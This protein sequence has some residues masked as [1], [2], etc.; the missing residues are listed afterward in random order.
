M[1]ATQ[2]GI[3]TFVRDNPTPRPP[4]RDA[5]ANASCGRSSTGYS[6]TRRRSVSRSTEIVQYIKTLEASQTKEKA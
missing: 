2:R 5:I 3:G 1:L 6:P 4:R